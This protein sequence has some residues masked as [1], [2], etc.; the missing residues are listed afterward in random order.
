MYNHGDSS[1][2]LQQYCSPFMKVSF[3]RT[4]EKCNLWFRKVSL[5]LT[6]QR[7]KFYA[8]TQANVYGHIHAT[9]P[10][11]RRSHR[12]RLFRYDPVDGVGFRLLMISEYS[13]YV[14][15][16]YPSK[17]YLLKEFERT[18]IHLAKGLKAKFKCAHRP[19]HNYESTVYSELWLYGLTFHWPLTSIM[20]ITNRKCADVCI[21]VWKRYFFMLNTTRVNLDNW[22]EIYGL[23]DARRP[24]RYF[25]WYSLNEDEWLEFHIYC[26]PFCSICWWSSV[27]NKRLPIRTTYMIL[28]QFLH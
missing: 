17:Y 25:V 28:L 10:S 5:D 9:T 14:G 8:K 7:Q 23:Q 15:C 16:K 2:K 24:N 13:I 20:G 19:T 6:S 12:K 3:L 11:R 22:K 21:F 26:L 18:Y 27:V 4:T 1:E